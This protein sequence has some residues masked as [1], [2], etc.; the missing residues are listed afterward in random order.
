VVLDR[1]IAGAVTTG[2]LVACFVML[3]IFAFVDFVSQMNSVG[4][5]DYGALQA[6]IYVLMRLPQRLYDLSPSILLLGGILSLGAMAANSEL[7]VMRASGISTMRITRSV[8]QTGL[9]IAILVALLG[10]Y[11]VPT[12]TR[13][14]K[15][16]RAEAMEKKLIVGNTNDIWAREGSRYV[17]VKQ[18]LPDRQL[19]NIRVYELDD[20]RQLRSIT[21]ARH[22]QYL[23]DEWVLDGIKR[24][25][26]SPSGVTTSFEKQL[27]MKRLI[28]LELFTVLELESNDMS[29]EELLTY[30]EYLQENKL[31]DSEYK[32]AFWIKIFTPL[33]CMAMLMIAMPIVFTTTPRSGGAGQR[34]MIALLIG[35]IY[36]V[37]NRSVNHLGL[38]LNI[39]PIFS[40][41]IPL[42]LV[43]L[44]S[45]YFMSRIK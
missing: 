5:G 30:S 8:L 23:N 38:A 31:D 37:I 34:L 11:A 25:E 36:F 14:A 17:N 18:I 2:C 26:I 24:T 29:A 16:Y 45:L 32:L 20:N 12:A 21:Y 41:A 9:L 33:T 1:Y 13:S 44:V 10:E 40:A 6:F 7:I 4:T 39:L 3:S 43:S 22:A 19:R 35:I 42:L 27:K 15:A 28:L